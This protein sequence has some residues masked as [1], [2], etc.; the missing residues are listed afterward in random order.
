MYPFLAEHSETF[1]IF[2]IIYIH[3]DDEDN[4]LSLLAQVKPRVNK[5]IPLSTH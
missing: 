3:L 1:K 5:L 4:P 2:E